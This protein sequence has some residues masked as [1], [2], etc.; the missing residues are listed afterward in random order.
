MSEEPKK[1]LYATWQEAFAAYFRAVEA[2]EAEGL[3]EQ[4]ETP[5]TPLYVA[6]EGAAVIAQNQFP[7]SVSLAADIFAGLRTDNGCYVVRYRET[8]GRQVY[9]ISFAGD[10][11]NTHNGS[12]W[13]A[14]KTLESAQEA[15]LFGLAKLRMRESEVTTI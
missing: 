14:L 11:I 15:G 9:V 5:L 10:G 12:G 2:G 7:G 6:R 4:F 3:R 8:I 1:F 13:W